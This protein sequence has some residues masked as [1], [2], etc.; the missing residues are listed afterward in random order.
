MFEKFHFEKREDRP[1]DERLNAGLVYG[2]LVIVVVLMISYGIEVMRGF[3]TEN[4]YLSFSL[5][6][7]I[8]AAV[9]FVLY[10][11]R[12]AWFY[13]RYLVLI[14]Y[15]AMYTYVM[16]TGVTGLTFTYILPLLSL[17]Y[18]TGRNRIL[19]EL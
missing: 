18:K 15:L 11:W 14:G 16:V 1:G 2:W 6:T 10:H 13:L 9:V 19:Q 3:R 17:L 12:P 5:L 4:Y 8:P 7:V